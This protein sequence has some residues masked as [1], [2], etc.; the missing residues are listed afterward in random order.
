MIKSKFISCL[1]GFIF[2]GILS[3]SYAQVRYIRL[4]DTKVGLTSFSRSYAMNEMAFGNVTAQSS[5]G[6]AFMPVDLG[7]GTHWEWISSDGIY[8]Q[9]NANTVWLYLAEYLRTGSNDPWY[10]SNRI[11]KSKDRVGVDIYALD[12]DAVDLELGIP[13]GEGLKIGYTFGARVFGTE[14]HSRGGSGNPSG[15]EVLT[16]GSGVF[17]H[18]PAVKVVG[19]DENM[20]V[21]AEYRWYRA[22]DALGLTGAAVRLEA[23]AYFGDGGGIFAAPYLEWTRFQSD[24]TAALDDVTRVNMFSIG[25]KV[26]LYVSSY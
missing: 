10:Y 7:I 24:F 26:G 18:G 6:N 22:K 9:I 2:F 17:F 25:A 20:Y 15:N 14:S 13:I 4:L 16:L 23:C 19:S 21:G 11:N 5:Y 12:Y 3:D 8:M 1:F